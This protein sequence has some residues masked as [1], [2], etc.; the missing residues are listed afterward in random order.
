MSF[1]HHWSCLQVVW[2]EGGGRNWLTVI[3]MLDKKGLRNLEYLF[4]SFFFMWYPVVLAW[5]PTINTRCCI[6]KPHRK[7]LTIKKRNYK[8][9]QIQWIIN[10]GWIAI[11][12]HPQSAVWCWVSGQGTQQ[13]NTNSFRATQFHV[14][15]VFLIDYN[16]RNWIEARDAYPRLHIKGDAKCFN[17]RPVKYSRTWPA[18]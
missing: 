14:G 16:I 18:C 12:I 8:Y 6:K 4:K 11:Q 5:I 17:V 9:Y 15:F 3:V 1:D 2:G 7:I 13:K 10:L